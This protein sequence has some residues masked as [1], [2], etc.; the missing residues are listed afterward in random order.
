MGKLKDAFPDLDHGYYWVT[1]FAVILALLS[2]VTSV[3]IFI[4]DQRSD[5][6]LSMNVEERN[7]MLKKAEE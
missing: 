7:K 5:R 4:W 6:I 2:L 3:V 1:R